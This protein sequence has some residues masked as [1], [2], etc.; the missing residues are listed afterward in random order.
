MQEFW[1]VW[2]LIVLAIAYGLVL[3]FIYRSVISVQMMKKV[4]DN[5]TTFVNFF[6]AIVWDEV[7]IILVLYKMK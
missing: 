5:P 6:F 7:R 1:N 4:K 3:V 2:E